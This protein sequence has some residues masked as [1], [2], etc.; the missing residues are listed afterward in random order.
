MQVDEASKQWMASVM[1]ATPLATEAGLAAFTTLLTAANGQAMVWSG[2]QTK[3]QK[4]LTKEEK[5][6]AT[7]PVAAVEAGEGVLETVKQHL[8]Q[9]MS[10]LLKIQPEH[11]SAEENLSEYGVDSIAFIGFTNQLN[12]YYQLALTPAVLFEHQT[13]TSLANYLVATYADAMVLRH[14]SKVTIPVMMAPKARSRYVS[15]S[16]ENKQPARVSEDIAIIGMSGVFPGS[17]DLT[18]FWDNLANQKDLITEIPPDRWDWQSVYGDGDNQTKVKWGGFIEGIDQF[19]RTI[20]LYFAAR[21]GIDGSTT[22]I[23]FR[24]GVEDH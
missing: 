24:S 18:S 13:I 5:V 6:E 17:P 9:M 11:L 12:E 4:Y 10:E 2:N 23:I 7:L 19:D 20:L 14:G 3:L 15:M 1:G 21:S 16:D 22:T 8:L